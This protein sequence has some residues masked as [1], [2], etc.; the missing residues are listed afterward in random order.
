MDLV[1]YKYYSEMILAK[2]E[3]LHKSKLKA[4][5]RKTEAQLFGDAPSG[6]TET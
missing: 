3:A 2:Q 6:P 4:S 1:E 5:V